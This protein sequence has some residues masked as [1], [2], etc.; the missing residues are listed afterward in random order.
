MPLS[1]RAQSLITRT[2]RRRR[3][4]IAVTVSVADF[5]PQ[6]TANQIRHAL[7]DI[8]T[9]I[10]K[11]EPTVTLVVSKWKVTLLSWLLGS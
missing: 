11:P 4:T 5:V 9:I 6:E 1:L 8:K 10:Q 3:A 7:K 2:S